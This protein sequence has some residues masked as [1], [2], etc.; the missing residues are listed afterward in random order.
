M[1]VYYIFLDL[2]WV[3]LYCMIYITLAIIQFYTTQNSQSFG[4]QLKQ[5]FI[6]IEVNTDLLKKTWEKIKIKTFS[7]TCDPYTTL[8][9]FSLFLPGPFHYLIVI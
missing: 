3:V 1:F 5:M 6:I 8:N 9:N 7:K 2:L 4:S